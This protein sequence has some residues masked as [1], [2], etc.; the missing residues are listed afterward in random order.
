MPTYKLKQFDNTNLE[1]VL[2]LATTIYDNTD[3]ENCP[4]ISCKLMKVG[5]RVDYDDVLLDMDK[6]EPFNVHATSNV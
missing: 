5:C 1:V 3:P 6:E 4:V 2:N